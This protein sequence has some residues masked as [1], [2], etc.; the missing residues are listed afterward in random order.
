MVSESYFEGIKH[1]YYK[2]I[3]KFKIVIHWCSEIRGFRGL[4]DYL[5]NCWEDFNVIFLEYKL[6]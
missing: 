4:D 5:Q 6:R 2:L 3:H 1:V